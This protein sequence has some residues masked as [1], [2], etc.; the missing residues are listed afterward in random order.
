[1]SAKE[2]ILLHTCCGPCATT[3]VE[4]L[5]PDREVVLFF[6]NSNI[7]P[8]AEYLKR[9]EHA[10]K[11]AGLLNIALREDTYDHQAWLAHVKGLEDEPEGGRRCEKCFAF[12]LAKTA[13]MAK[14][15]G[16]PAFTTSLSVSRYKSSPVIFSVGKAFETFLPMDFKKRDGYARSIEL[17]RQYGL[18]RQN[19]CGCEF[20]RQSGNRS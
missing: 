17:S 10:G 19:Y 2:Q 20:S 15:L 7:A 4:R 11:L 13:A 8:E 18:Y 14:A 6:S 9:L 1:M 12:S 16:I 3:C 5:L